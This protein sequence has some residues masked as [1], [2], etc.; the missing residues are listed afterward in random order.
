MSHETD[1]ENLNVIVFDGGIVTVA[2]GDC[3]IEITA[4]SNYKALLAGT[5]EVL[6]VDDLYDCTLNGALTNCQA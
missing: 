3:P 6:W 5:N 1:F 4:K 2:P